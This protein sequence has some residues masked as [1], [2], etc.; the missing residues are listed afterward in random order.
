M[1]SQTAADAL[2]ED[3]EIAWATVVIEALLPDNGV[4]EI[5]GWV[6]TVCFENTDEPAVTIITTAGGAREGKPVEQRLIPIE[7]VCEI[8]YGWDEVERNG[9]G[10]K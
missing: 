1:T 8:R 4:L 9:G 2:R 10:G 6:V 3:D 5:D 7:R